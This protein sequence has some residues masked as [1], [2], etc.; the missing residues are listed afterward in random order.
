[1][2]RVFVGVV[3]SFVAVSACAKEGGFLGRWTIER[4]DSAPWNEAGYTPDKAIADTY[5]GKTVRFEANRIDGPDLLACKNT[6][7][8]FVDVPAEGL[9]QGGLAQTDAEIPK[10]R[11]TAIK[12]GFKTQPIRTAT[13]NCEHDIAFHMS[14][15]DHAAFALDN[16]IF[17]MKRVR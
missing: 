12:M 4:A 17:W 3:L 14:D 5:V 1:M 9:F 7:Y 13:T 16:W 6:T 8:Q 2:K 10:A 11:E 15:D